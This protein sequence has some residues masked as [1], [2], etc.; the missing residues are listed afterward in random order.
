M[1][2]HYR[3]K[4]GVRRNQVSFRCNDTEYDAISARARAA[5]IKSHSEY[6]RHLVLIAPRFEDLE[7]RIAA[8]EEQAAREEQE[9]LKRFKEA[10]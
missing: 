2:P 8:I 7:R 1:K 4:D 5:G 3:H 9:A 6:I 10:K